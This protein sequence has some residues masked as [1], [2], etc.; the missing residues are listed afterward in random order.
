[1]NIF[2]YMIM[3]LLGIAIGDFWRNAIY[4]IPR[5][6]SL[7]KRNVTNIESN[8]KSEKRQKI[9]F[10]LLGGIIFVICGKI[11][12]IDINSLQLRTGMLYIFT[13]LYMSVLVVIAG[14]DQKYLKIDTKV[15]T[16]G[17]ILSVLYIIYLYIIDKTSI[18]INAIYLG[19]FIVL[20]AI[21]TFIIK[22]YAKNNYTIGIL[23]LFTIILILSKI[24]IFMYTL[25]LTTLE[26]LVSIIISKIN[27]KR[28]GYKKI[29]LSNIPVGYFLTVSNMFCLILIPVI[30]KI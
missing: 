4:R 27:Q 23:T 3:F 24:E 29:T 11:L 6:I 15:I 2:L 10:L 8:N 26:I 21:D 9:F 22:R 7:L 13:I 12:Q 28:N 25:I 17:I 1:M 5:N 20:L 16:S 19:V 30:T 14:I 18:K